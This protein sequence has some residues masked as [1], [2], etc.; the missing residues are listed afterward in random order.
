MDLSKTIC[1]TTL[2]FYSDLSGRIGM[3]AVFDNH[4][5]NALWGQD[6]LTQC[7]PSMQF[8]EL[9][10]LVTAVF[11]WQDRLVNSRFQVFC[12]NIGAKDAV[13]NSSSSCAK[14]MNLIRLLVQNNMKYNRQ[15]FVVYVKS[16]SNVLADA[17]SRADF[18]RFWEHVPPMMMDKPDAIP[19]EIWSPEKIWNM[20]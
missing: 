18:H 5:I 8:L 15:I 4:W 14:C 19:V 11:M 13:N 2:N 10:A 1:A 16:K 17:L 3:G 20:Y 12:D 7:N 6:F 9:Y